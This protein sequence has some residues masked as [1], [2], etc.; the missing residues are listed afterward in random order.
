MEHELSLGIKKYSMFTT[1]VLLE[2]SPVGRQG[3]LLLYGFRFS[4]MRV[5]VPSSSS[6]VLGTML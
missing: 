3:V 6:V 4:R 5:K 1:G 2:N